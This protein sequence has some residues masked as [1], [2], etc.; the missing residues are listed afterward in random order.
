VKIA[1]AACILSLLHGLGQA[2]LS[3]SAYRVLGQ[4]NLTENAVNR[5]Q[6][7]EMNGPSAMALDWRD[8]V[9]HLY[10]ADAANHR[11]LAW[12]D[13][14]SYQTGDAPTLV[15]GQPGPR[16]ASPLGIGAKGFNSPLGMTVDPGNGDLYVADFGNHRV[17]RFPNPFAH[18]TRV[19]PDAV[20][21]QPDYASRG[22]NTGGVGPNSMNGP[23]AV[24]MDGSGNL[25]V[26][27]SGNHRVL[28]FP[29]A[30]LNSPAPGADL[31]LGQRDFLSNSANRSGEGVSGSGFDTPAGVALDSRGNLFVSDYLNARVLK[32]ASPVGPNATAAAVYGQATFTSRG[33]PRQPSSTTLAGPLGLA[34]APGT[35]DLYVAVPGDNR[36]LVF[37][38][39]AASGAAAVEVIGQPDLASNLPNAFSFPLASARSLRSPSDVKVDGD[40][41]VYVADA[42]NQ[43]VICFPPN[44]KT[45]TKVWGQTDLA[46]N[47]ANRI[48]PGSIHAPFK[49]AIDYS[50]APF[51]L[52]VSDTNN[53]RVLGWRDAARFRSGDPAE[54]VIGQPDFST[55][56]PNIDAGGSQN[57]ARTSLA[58]PRGIAVDT[59]GDLYVADSGNNRVL[60]YPRPFA[61]S[62]RV[63]PDRV[64]GQVD[65]TTATSAA[66]SASSLRAPAGVATGPSGSLFVADSG[67]H[68]VLEFGP[69]AGSSASAIRVFGQPNFTSTAPSIPASAQTMTSPQGIFVD[70]A[71]AL[72]VADSGNNRVLI[73]ANTNEAPAAG[74]AAVVVVG[75]DAFDA[76]SEGSGATRLRLPVDV[77]GDGEGNVIVTDSGNHRVLIFPSLLF[78]PI[79]GAAA[80]AVIGQRDVHSAAVN[81]NSVNGLATPE[82]LW[83]PAGLLVDRQ[84]TLYVGDAGN[85]RVLHY[86]KTA[87]VAHAAS[88]QAGVPLARGGIAE[89][90][91]PMLG[92]E[93][94]TAG[95]TSWPLA[96]AGRELVLND[97][98]PA[99]LESI[100]AGRV[101]FQVP[102][103]A[104]TGTQPVAVRLA[105]T[106]EL[107]A[108]TTAVVAES[109][110]GLFSS[111]GA[112]PILNFDRT[113]NGPSNPAQRGSLIHIFGTGQGP[114]S[115]VV[116]DGEAAPADV[117]TIAVPTT[118]GNACRNNQPSVCVAIGTAFGGIEFSGLA[119]GLVGVWQISVR[120][121]VNAAAGN[122]V[123]LRA[124]IN[125]IPSNIV[126]AAIR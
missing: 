39:A 4:A 64:I 8:G 68:R 27:D 87:K 100:S 33:V 51:A 106:A 82:G 126:T 29:A 114:V 65:F 50:Q 35:G 90:S 55:A 60:R 12:Q 93:G 13:A 86:L 40:G 111:P 102:S 19:E 124:L 6:G 49:I 78:L 52:Y 81:W 91:G 67:N 116:K 43:R 36:V 28:R 16:H 66:V 122:A 92:R 73:F 1:H 26:A 71:S 5:V 59:A 120:I 117:E 9:P 2:Q 34:V 14:R 74:S 53:H 70:G 61:Q 104:E 80:T 54:L 97:Q 20:Y 99:A 31:V 123:P 41:N 15:L 105:E 101:R 24:A 21:G 69:G 63:A 48:K 77:A 110:P 119:P 37:P 25:W 103:S 125:G 30:V 57:P 89:L 85:N 88:A 115:P 113:P 38:A 3:T 47:G 94:Q 95:G 72:Y 76:A 17:L 75:Q 22:A 108:G 112:H 121:P 18:P 96:L 44:S 107:I 83:A 11:V 84:D 42:N 109:S 58:F 62:G 79:S 118:D 45:A 46:A 23:R 10:V 98:I 56:I 7:V 32:F